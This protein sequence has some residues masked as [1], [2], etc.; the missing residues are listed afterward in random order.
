[1]SRAP[2]SIRILKSLHMQCEPKHIFASTEPRYEHKNHQNCAIHLVEDSYLRCRPNPDVNVLSVFSSQHHMIIRHVHVI[3]QIRTNRDDM[4]SSICAA[5]IAIN[6]SQKMDR[7]RPVVIADR[8][9]ENKRTCTCA[10]SIVRP[11]NVI[12]RSVTLLTVA[13]CKPPGIISRPLDSN[14]PHADEC[15]M[16][17]GKSLNRW[18][19]LT[20]SPFGHWQVSFERRNKFGQTEWLYSMMHRNNEALMKSIWPSLPEHTHNKSTPRKMWANTLLKRAHTH[21]TAMRQ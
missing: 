5:S 3:I 2:F 8:I 1:M 10:Q 9:I 4:S 6:P 13:I 15:L 16:Q 21:T 19:V 18:Q 14:S 20:Q 17:N 7:R 12:Q 11:T